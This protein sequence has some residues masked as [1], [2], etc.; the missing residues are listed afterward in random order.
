MKQGFEFSEEQ[1]A[2]IKECAELL[3]KMKEKGITLVWEQSDSI[4][5]VINT[6]KIES[7]HDGYEPPQESVNV[8]D[9][10]KWNVFDYD[11]IFDY[12]DYYGD[13]RAIMK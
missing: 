3:K 6:S 5:G 13:L 4:L 1:N 9:A 12:D 10:V 2:L 11:C 8:Q 7:L